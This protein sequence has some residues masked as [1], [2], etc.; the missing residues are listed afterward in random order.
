MLLMTQV[1]Q[2]PID[3]IHDRLQG[4]LLQSLIRDIK[5][6]EFP[7][8]NFYYGE[9]KKALPPKRSQSKYFRFRQ[10]QFVERPIDE[11]FEFFDSS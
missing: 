4:E 9:D 6:L 11:V 2:I 3:Q 10:Y 7:Y 8:Q 5:D 1:D